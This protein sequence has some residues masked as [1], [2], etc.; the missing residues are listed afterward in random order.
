[1]VSHQEPASQ[2]E[3]KEAV[4]ISCNPGKEKQDVEL[5]EQARDYSVSVVIPA[6]NVE[7]Y[8]GRAIDSVLAQTYSA[9]EIIVVDDGSTDNTP[10]VL[11]AYGERIVNIAQAN[12]GPS[13]ARNTGIE[14]ASGFWIA[15]LDADDEWLPDK[16]LRQVELLGRWPNL[17]WCGCNFVR[18]YDR[19]GDRQAYLS[20]LQLAEI[21]GTGEVVARC[22]Q[23]V[24]LAGDLPPCSLLIRREVFDQVG[25]FMPELRYTEDADMWW[26]ITYAF[27]SMGMVSEP[28]AVYHVARSGSLTSTIEPEE[29]CRQNVGFYARHKGLA[30][31][32]GQLKPLLCYLRVKLRGWLLLMY[33]RKNFAGVRHTLQRAG[34]ILPLHSRILLYLLTCLPKRASSGGRFLLEL[35]RWRR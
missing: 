28:M 1:V 8:I 10:A 24:L 30:A 4:T 33:R 27:P 7:S 23:M 13:I 17:A 32:A 19:D 26:R 16:L 34:N 11:S 20:P 35:L 15:F 31:N 21:V 5:R 18:H 29:V 9:H 22:Y 14:R 6:Y 12:A 25:R 3:T 2:L